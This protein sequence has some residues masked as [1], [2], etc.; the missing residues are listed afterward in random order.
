MDDLILNNG[1]E[2]IIPQASD[3]TIPLT[4]EIPVDAAVEAPV[5]APID[6]PVGDTQNTE[7]DTIDKIG[8]FFGTIQESITIAWRFHLKTKKHSAHVALKE[9]YDDALDIVDDIIEQYQGATSTTIENYYNAICDCGK[10][11]IEYF[12]ELKSFVVS[13]KSEI[14][15]ETE[16]IST[17]DDLLSLIDS[18]LY[19]LTSFCE[20]SIKTFE[21]F[22]FEDYEVMGVEGGVDGVFDTVTKTTKT[23]VVPDF[24]SKN[25]C[26]DCPD[27]PDCDKEEDDDEEEE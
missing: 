20:H 11:D 7:D 3:T 4:P 26:K 10:S 23:N 24:K 18:T 25:K 9:Y 17:I 15:F 1:D 12:Q 13:S 2:V 16:I 27:C 5:E 19:K 14:I 21:E 8:R 6:V 22:C